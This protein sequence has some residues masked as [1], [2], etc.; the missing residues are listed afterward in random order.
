MAANWGIDGNLFFDKRE[1]SLD[2]F[3]LAPEPDRVTTYHHLF[4]DGRLG[5]GYSSLEEASS[6]IELPIYVI[7][8]EQQEDGTWKIVSSEPVQGGAL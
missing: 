8:T 3:L 1:T 4:S 7:T 2:L 5:F 6:S